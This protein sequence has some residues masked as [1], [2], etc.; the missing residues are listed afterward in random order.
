MMVG[1]GI[2]VRLVV[3][4]GCVVPWTRSMGF[5]GCALVLCLGC[6]VFWDLGG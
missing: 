6:W 2:V 1:G 3:R 5:G 4:V